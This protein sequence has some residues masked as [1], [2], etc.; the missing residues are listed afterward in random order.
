MRHGCDHA[1]HVRFD[2][3]HFIVEYD[4]DGNVLRIKERKQY[5]HGPGISG[6]YNASYW[7]AS[8]HVLGSGNTMPKRIL[9][10]ATAKR[11]AEDRNSDATP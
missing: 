10:A 4:E 6:T 5:D 1:I 8:S 2:D 7:V 11:A 9:A 3:R